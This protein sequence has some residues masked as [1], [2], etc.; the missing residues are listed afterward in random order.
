MIMSMLIFK[1]KKSRVFRD[2][3]VPQICQ[4]KFYYL[5][6]ILHEINTENM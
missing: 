3:A 5:A 2:H 4:E 1:N 6:H